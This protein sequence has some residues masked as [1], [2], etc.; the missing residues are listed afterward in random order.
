MLIV[1]RMTRLRERLVYHLQAG[2]RAWELLCQKPL[3]TFMTVMVIATALILPTL[4]FVV[5]H[6]T[7]QLTANWQQG[8]HISLYLKASSTAQNDDFLQR[9]RMLQGVDGATLK[10]PAE[11]LFELQQQEGMKDV[12]R[13]LPENPLPAVIDVTPDASINTPAL[14]ETLYQRLITFPE[15]EQGMFDTQW[16]SKFHAVLHFATHIGQGCMILLAVAVMLIIANT[17]RLTLYHRYEEVRILK[18]I[19]AADPYIVR[20]FLYL[21]AYYG[22]A[23][24]LFAVFLINIVM[25]YIRIPVNAL[26]AIYQMHYALFGLSFNQSLLLIVLT[27]IMGLFSAKLSIMRQISSIEPSS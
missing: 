14:L 21:G 15:V 23:G 5:I 3:A 16:V 6:N 25:L 1:D 7:K 13:Y 18:L 11:G 20:P 2:Q 26:A 17:L 19:G 24:A 22:L 4:F 8:G 27:I 10:S 12:L 9:V